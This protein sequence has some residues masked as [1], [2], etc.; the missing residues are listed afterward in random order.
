MG[1]FFC[2][3][4]IRFIGGLALGINWH[5]FSMA[6]RY[7]LLDVPSNSL[8][9]IDETAF[10][11]F[12]THPE[13][14]A[15]D[16]GYPLSPELEALRQ[17]VLELQ[18]AGYCRPE[19][20]ERVSTVRPAGLKALC[21]HL[22]HDCNLRCRYCFAGEGHYG[23]DRGL[24]SLEVGQAAIDFLLRESGERKQLEVDFFGGEPLLNK[25]V[26]KELV[27]YGEA[28]GQHCGKT[29]HFTLTTNTLLLD[30]EI[31]H[32][33]HEH[34]MGLVMSLDG[35]PEINDAMR[36]NGSY[37]RILPQILRTVQGPIGSY[38]YVRGT[39]TG[40][41]LDFAED[42]LHIADQGITE[43]SVEPVIAKPD[44]EYAI[45]PEYLERVE[46][47]YERLAQAYL[48]RYGTPQQFR[49]FH[50]EVNLDH[51]PCVHKRLSGC[52]AG[53]DYLAV[54]PDGDLYPCHQFVGREDY[55]IGDLKQ[56][57][58]RPELRDRFAQANIYH[59]EGCAECWARYHCS[60]G[61]HANAEFVN[62]SILKPDAVG[63]RLQKKRLECA[64]A[65][66]AILKER[67]TKANHVSN[68]E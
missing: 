17:D 64:L 15:V 30:D 46:A 7:F 40:K 22:A 68:G 49:F 58:I 3:N 42:V 38:Y 45:R 12:S 4:G 18:N 9:S 66:K 54:T 59:K 47:E 56:G 13:I 43:I 61:C 36:G 21:L 57:I 60:G 48:E 29:L 63:C 37:H 53:Y 23:Q 65:I 26:L 50:F 2:P 5:V 52:G 25:E 33:I 51:G 19:P 39:Y 34:H 27:H 10:Q 14:F 31:R 35:R 11:V 1:L 20:E 6:G 8:F 16:P 67:E 44:D 28:A 62:G 55:R 32:F 41:N 24:M